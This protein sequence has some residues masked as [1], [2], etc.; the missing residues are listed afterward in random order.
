MLTS[1]EADF[2]AKARKSSIDILEFG[3]AVGAMIR[4]LDACGAS[5]GILRFTTRSLSSFMQTKDERWRRIVC[6]TELHEEIRRA[7]GLAACK[8]KQ[9]FSRLYPMRLVYLLCA[10]GSAALSLVSGLG[11]PHLQ[12]GRVEASPGRRGDDVQAA[13]HGSAFAVRGHLGHAGRLSDDKSA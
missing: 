5:V 11:G 2:N 6:P 10:F 7:G 1:H 4:T 9:P 8:S 12:R 13:R 3:V